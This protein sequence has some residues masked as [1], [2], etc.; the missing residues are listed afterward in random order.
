MIQLKEI[1]AIVGVS[2]ATVSNALNN[3][4]N[5]SEE[6][7]KRIIE[8]CE[9]HGYVASNRSTK[10]IKT[11]VFNFSD[12]DRSFYLNVIKGINTCLTENGY[13]LIVCT[14]KSCSKFM[15]HPHSAG[16]ICLDGKMS[17][18][19]LIQL[20]NEK[21]P[22]VVMDRVLNHPFIKSV[23][24]DNYP[25][26][27]DLIQ[28]MI[29]KGYKSFAFVGGEKHTL[30]NQERFLAFEYTLKKNNIK[31]NRRHY[32]HGDYREK[33]GYQAATLMMLDN[34][35]PQA[36]ICASD[37]MALGAMKAFRERGI[38]VPKDVAVTGFDNS[39]AASIGGLTTIVIPRYE[40]GFI[41]AK[42]LLD[43][44]DGAA[45]CETSKL[46]ATIKW[47]NSA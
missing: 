2:P 39:D 43:F 20:A 26:M 14:T 24:V 16:A 30:D 44:I 6:L 32:Y 33:S 34:T 8:A 10:Q 45:S 7:K 19:Q 35:L 28:G 1:A 36:L 12:F 11:I 9:Q 23:L 29:D 38:S 37:S 40:Y 27:C 47:R 41:A 22:L 15:Q 31:F 4:K 46:S 21:Y 18:E 5:I 13:D 25:V 42:A 3:K 17:D